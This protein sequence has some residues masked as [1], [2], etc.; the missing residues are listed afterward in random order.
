MLLTAEK[1][2]R[3]K[4]I[5]ILELETA[6]HMA[7][8][9][10][11][12]HKLVEAEKREMDLAWKLRMLVEVLEEGGMDFSELGRRLDIKIEESI[13]GTSCSDPPAPSET[14]DRKPPKSPQ[15]QHRRHASSCLSCSKSLL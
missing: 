13:W 8:G 10:D 6:L 11:W 4:T 5:R 7:A 1:V 9:E 14:S 15:T 12:K 2:C 3:E